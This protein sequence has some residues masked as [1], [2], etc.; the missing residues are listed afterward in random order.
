MCRLI[1]S[2]EKNNYRIVVEL[3]LLIYFPIEVDCE[4]FDAIFKVLRLKVNFI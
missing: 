4:D 3:S 2:G 1:N